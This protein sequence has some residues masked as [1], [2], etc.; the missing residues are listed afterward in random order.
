LE[1]KRVT[2]QLELA[3][4]KL[5]AINNEDQQDL[6]DDMENM[7]LEYIPLERLS[8]HVLGGVK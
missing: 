8:R 2:N 5:K 3:A 6:H 4:R 1:D 7:D